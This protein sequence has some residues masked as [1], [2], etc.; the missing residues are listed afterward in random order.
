VGDQDRFHDVLTPPAS[1]YVVLK[2]RPKVDFSEID[3]PRL[4][5]RLLGTPGKEGNQK[6]TEETTNQDKAFS[7]MLG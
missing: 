6:L 5:W 7:N 1:L 2:R 4:S 3:E